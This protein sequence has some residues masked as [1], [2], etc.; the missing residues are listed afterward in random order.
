MTADEILQKAYKIASGD[1]EPLSSGDPSYARALEL[2]NMFYDDWVHEPLHIMGVMWSSLEKSVALKLNTDGSLSLP[3]NVVA[4]ASHPLRIPVSGL[5]RDFGLDG[6]KRISDMQEV[7]GENFWTGSSNDS[8]NVDWGVR[9]VYVLN[10]TLK[11]L[12]AEPDLNFVLATY[13]RPPIFTAHSEVLIDNPNWLIYMLAAELARTDILQ[14][15]QYGNLVALA[16]NTMDAMT[17][18]ERDLRFR[19]IP[20]NTRGA[21]YA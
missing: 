20:P 13:S 14:S 15:G 3:R 21:L 6:E 9:R 8:F 10:A 7:S 16:Q 11:R 19:L 4:I 2:M 12:R 1:D 5:V 17:K 18:A